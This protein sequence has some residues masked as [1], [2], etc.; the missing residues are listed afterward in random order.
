MPLTLSKSV[1]RDDYHYFTTDRAATVQV[2]R[3]T[4]AGK[5]VWAVFHPD[6]KCAIWGGESDSLEAA[7]AEAG[8][9]VSDWVRP[10]RG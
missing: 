3:S 10:A 1:E 2:G 8:A 7:K 9:W 5:Y 4:N 6:V